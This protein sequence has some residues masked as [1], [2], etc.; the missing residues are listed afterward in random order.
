[1]QKGFFNLKNSGLLWE[2]QLLAFGELNSKKFLMKFPGFVH[3]QKINT[4][5]LGVATQK[6]TLF[7]VETSYD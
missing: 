6:L 3:Q 7:G 5:N 4:K 1:M 2:L